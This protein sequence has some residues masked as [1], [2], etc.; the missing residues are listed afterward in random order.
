LPILR[1]GSIIA[2]MPAIILHLLLQKFLL[3]GLTTG[4]VKE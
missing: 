2:S 1:T 3:A 4:A